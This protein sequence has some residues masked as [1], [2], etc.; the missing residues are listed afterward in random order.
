MSSSQVQY[1]ENGSGHITREQSKHE[2]HEVYSNYMHRISK[3]NKGANY[4]INLR[5]SMDSV[6]NWVNP[7]FYQ[8]W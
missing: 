4:D 3:L 5:N 7:N 2:K 6:I 8:V 1:Q